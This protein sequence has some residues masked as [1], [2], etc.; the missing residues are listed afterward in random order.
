MPGELI[1]MVK[2]EMP[3]EV[4]R[5][6]QKNTGEDIMD[7]VMDALNNDFGETFKNGRVKAGDTMD[8]IS[9][10]CEEAFRQGYRLGRKER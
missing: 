9:R 2:L 7:I 3:D 6:I 10:H 4:W 1:E 8:R 5:R